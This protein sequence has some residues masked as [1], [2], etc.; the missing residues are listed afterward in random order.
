MDKLLIE[1]SERLVGRSERSIIRR[2]WE[3][4]ILEL[5]LNRHA[6]PRPRVLWIL[7]VP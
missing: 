5:F 6:L 4:C 3:N 1:S 7:R 2:W